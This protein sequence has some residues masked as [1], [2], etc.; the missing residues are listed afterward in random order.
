MRILS[1]LVRIFAGLLV[2]FVLLVLFIRSPWG[3][4]VIKDRLVSYITSQTES[5]VTLDRIYL[6]FSGDLTIEDL[7]VEDLNQDTLLYS[8]L[9]TADIPI[10]PILTGGAITVNELTWKDVRVNIHREA[11]KNDFNYQFLLSAFASD[12]T[13]PV[14]PED[15]STEPVDIAIRKVILDQINAGYT[16][17]RIGLAAQISL[18]H[19]QLVLEKSDIHTMEFEIREALLSDSRITYTQTKPFPPSEDTTS[20]L[21]PVLA[22]HDIRLDNVTGSY[23][24]HPDG[25]DAHL[26]VNKFKLSAPK[27]DLQNQNFEVD[28]ISLKQSG[29]TILQNPGFLENADPGDPHMDTATLAWVWPDWQVSVEQINLDDN[30]ISYQVGERTQPVGQFDPEHLELDQF[31]LQSRGISLQPQS[32]TGQIDQWS[33]QESSG[34]EL[35]AFGL[36]LEMDDQDLNLSEVKIQTADSRLSG[37]IQVSYSDLQTLASKPENTTISVDIPLINLSIDEVLRFLPE[38]EDNPY[39]QTLGQ[40]PITIAFKGEGTLHHFNVPTAKVHWGRTT[41]VLASGSIRHLIRPSD[42]QFDFP[43]ILVTS[44]RMDMNSLMP[45]DSLGIRYPESTHLTAGLSGSMEDAMA[46]I[47]LNSDLGQLGLSG[48]ISNKEVLRYD[49][50]VRTDSLLLDSLLNYPQLGPLTL[51]AQIE[52]EGTALES[53]DLALE[54]Q[55]EH[56]TFDGYPINDLK[57]NGWAQNGQGTFNS[58]YRDTNLQVNLDGRFILDTIS[59]ELNI[60]LQVPGVDMAALSLTEEEIKMGFNLEAWFAGNVTRFS[61]KALL[62]DGI[63]VRDGQNYPMGEIEFQA[64]VAPDTT[65]GSFQSKALD[66]RLESNTSPE[67]FTTALMHHIQT[68]IG[69]STKISDN[70][71]QVRVLMNGALREDPLITDVFLPDLEEIDT[72]T[73]DVEFVEEERRLTALIDAPKILYAGVSIDSVRMDAFSDEDQFTMDLA[74]RQIESGPVTINRTVFT[75]EISDKVLYSHFQAMDGNEILMEMK[76]E[77]SGQGDSLRIH[78]DPSVLVFD[79]NDWSVPP[80]NEIITTKNKILFRDFRFHRGEQSVTIDDNPGLTDLNVRIQNFKLANILSYF[81]PDT[82]LATGN[83]NGS[84]TLEEPLGDAGLIADLGIDSLKVLDVNMGDLRLF[85]VT[86]DARDYSV[87]LNLNGGQ[88]DFKVQGAYQATDEDAYLTLDLQIDTINMKAIEAFS[89]GTIEKS[90]GYLTGLAR[91]EGPISDLRY[92][93]RI[94]FHNAGTTP[95]LLQT[96]FTLGQQEITFN[97]ESIVLHDFSISDV[98]GNTFTLNGDILTSDLFNPE[99]NLKMTAR[100]FQILNAAQDENEWVYGKAGF[101]ARATLT[102]NLNFPVLDMELE[103]GSGTDLTYVMPQGQAQINSRD[104][105]VSFV[106]KDNPSDIL[107]EDEDP[108]VIRGYEIDALI[109]VHEDA[110]FQVIISEETGD[111]FKISGDGELLLGIDRAGQMTLTG[112]YTLQD[113]A[114]EMNLYNLVN[115]NFEIVP[116]STVSWSGDPFDANINVRAIYRVEASPASLMASQTS[117]ADPVVQNQY[118]RQLPFLVYLNVDGRLTEPT[119][120]FDID[121]PENVRGELGGQVYGRIQQINQQEQLVNKQV[122]S[123]LVLNRFYPDQGSDG[124]SGGIVNVARDNLNDA[125]SDQLNV[126]SDRLLGDT[127]FELNFGLESYTDY[128]PQGQNPQNRTELDI[129]AQKSF[130][131]DRLIVNVGSEID[132]EGSNSS[133]GNHNP[134]IGNVSVEYLITEN[135]QFRIRGFRKNVYE[136]VID[137]QTIVSGLALIFTR[138]FNKFRE[139]WQPMAREEGLR[140]TEENNESE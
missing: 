135:G 61:T 109:R 28:E 63:V 104:G 65:A 66:L 107:Q 80:T 78:L 51:A 137:G 17:Q 101:D 119:L 67:G 18:G 62:S 93:G 120:S 24:S 33:F 70:T 128:G 44:T 53:L 94:N 59:P 46:A 130:L 14:P 72:V 127:G 47:T 13:E 108:V 90:S 105:I 26:E 91:A 35:T 106:N 92:D 77:M 76:T 121:M 74:L 42:M 131:N 8:G 52:G 11:D 32:L 36:A 9:L 48:R 56:F 5:T 134:L 71:G 129:S 22:L 75:N 10:W 136:N 132:I 68:Y 73:I 113:G 123:L 43:R 89:A 12:A 86:E 83:L 19:F 50:K 79:S 30:R 133:P 111:H 57:I 117:A 139:L 3:Q 4:D 45:E 99:F 98:D 69:D 85:S 49:L 122:F 58:A 124:S 1:I 39:I 81:N 110:S 40:K 103:V 21:L 100:N 31:T 54:S 29:I 23:L 34:F 15:K 25:L 20:F 102:G 41:S 82:L 37:D 140:N 60:N 96:P 126:F 16:D 138:E 116:G 6:T 112:L 7:Y 88:V 38:L 95:A 87:D 64:F 125:L 27:V 2:I 55:I 84:I 118:R 97:N 115:R 114:Y